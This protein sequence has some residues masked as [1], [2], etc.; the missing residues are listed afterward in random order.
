MAR[1]PLVGRDILFGVALGITVR[2]I[3]LGHLATVHALGYPL[4]PDMP[5]LNELLGTHVVIARVLS[6]V[7]NAVFNA[8]FTVVRAWCFSRSWCAGS[9]SRQSWPWC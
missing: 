3:Y 8:L 4:T 2:V 1:Y 9:V 7:F 6:Q 5:D